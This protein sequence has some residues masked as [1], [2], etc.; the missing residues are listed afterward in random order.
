MVLKLF[1]KIFGSRNDRLIKKY[2][3]T[4]AQISACEADLQK[5]SDE[6]L[7]DRLLKRGATSGRADDQDESII[8]NRIN[9]YKEQTAVVGQF[10]AKEGKF[11]EVA[12]EG[13]INEIFARLTAQIEAVMA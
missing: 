10:Y 8:A 7:K 5:L 3:K 6:E 13:E 1:T 2:R 9:V 4:V 11:Q 12:G